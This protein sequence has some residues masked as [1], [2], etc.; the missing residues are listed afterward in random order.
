MAP[1]FH[2]FDLSRKKYYQLT[3]ATLR[4]RVVAHLI[5]GFFLSIICNVFFMAFS[6]SKIYSLWISPLVPQFIFEVKGEFVSTPSDF[7]WGGY[8]FPWHLPWHKTIYLNY[9]APLLWLIYA[10]Y[11]TGFNMI[12]GQT[13]G[14]MMK[15]LVVI[16]KSDNFPAAIVSLIRWLLIILSLLPLGMGFWG[17]LKRVKSENWHDR[18]CRTRVYSFE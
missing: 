5:D 15:K 11:F 17:E 18:I 1:I 6:N 3:P 14:K 2:R 10:I 4:E 12:A 16:N 8:L 13:P 9:P 7:W